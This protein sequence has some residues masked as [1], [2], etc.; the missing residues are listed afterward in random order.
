MTTTP[1]PRDY[2]QEWTTIQGI[3]FT[4]PYGVFI[5]RPETEKW[6]LRAMQEYRNDILESTVL[7]DLCS[8]AGL[9]SM[10]A[11]KRFPATTIVSLDINPLAIEAQHKTLSKN[12]VTTVSPRISDL[13]TSAKVSELSNWVLFSNP[14]YVPEEDR[15]YMQ[16]HNIEHEPQDAIFGG[17]KSGLDMFERILEQM[18]QYALPKVAFFELDPRNI[19]LASK[20]AKSALNPT[21]IHHWSDENGWHRVLVLEF[22]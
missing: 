1:I 10:M 9:I 21:S 15:Q 7:V 8:G 18:K 4:I 6:V 13:L 22:R 12:S 11:A 16:E 2:L 3:D 17:G 19:L 5:P 20:Y 14:P